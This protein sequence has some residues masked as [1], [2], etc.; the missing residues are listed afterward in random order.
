VPV[1]LSVLLA[2]I[3]MVES[4]NDPNAVGDKHLKN[5]AY[6]RYQI[7]KPYLDDVN[8]VLH[9]D[10][11]MDDVRKHDVIGK[12]A[13]LNYLH[14]WGQ[15]YTNRTGLKPSY[16]VLARIHNGGPRGYQKQSTVAYWFKVR[17]HL[18]KA[19]AIQ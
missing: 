15:K 3:A 19:G 12:C 7:R 13:V 10:F 18:I 11:T 16:E 2:A 6:G 9:S 14:W 17:K 4:G 1:N 5:Q 8:R